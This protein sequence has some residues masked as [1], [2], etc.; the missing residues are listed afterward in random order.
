MH[1]LDPKVEPYTGGM[2]FL[3]RCRAKSSVQLPL[4]Q[5]HTALAQTSEEAAGRALSWGESSLL[6]SKRGQIQ[7][8]LCQ[9]TRHFPNFSVTDS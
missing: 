7:Q 8:P 1:L 6:W 4:S 2:T 5:A 9:A 3:G